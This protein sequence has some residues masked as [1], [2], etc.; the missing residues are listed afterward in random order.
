[1]SEVFHISYGESCQP[2]NDRQKGLMLGLVS[3][4]LDKTHEIAVR[5]REIKQKHGLPAHFEM[6]W[7]KVS[8]AGTPWMNKT[9][10]SARSAARSI[11]TANSSSTSPRVHWPRSTPSLRRWKSG[12]WNYCAR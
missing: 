7:T 8:P 12:S 10:V 11:S 3:C 4:P 9:A 6:K 5:L 1:M 2:E